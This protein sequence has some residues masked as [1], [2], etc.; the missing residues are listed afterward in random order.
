MLV[1][2]FLEQSARR[3]P[4]KVALVTKEGRFSYR[5]IDEMANKVA[6]ALIADRLEKGDRVAI[7]MDNSLEAVVGI[8][9]VLKAGGIFFTD[10]PDNQG[11]ET[12]LCI[13]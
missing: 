11:R 5:E 6:N 7:F 12:Y 2:Q 1:N 4:D 10:K 13:E 9:G 8:F 3:H